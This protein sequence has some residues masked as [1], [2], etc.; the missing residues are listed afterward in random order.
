MAL[1][2]RLLEEQGVAVVAGEGFGAPGH[3]RVSLATSLEDLKE[4][5]RRMGEF[6][7]RGPAHGRR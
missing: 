5:V 6:F 3:L 2:S 7:S 4:G 1:A